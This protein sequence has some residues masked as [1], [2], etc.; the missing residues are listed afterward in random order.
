M[1]ICAKPKKHR[2]TRKEILSLIESQRF[3][4]A[5]SGIVLTPDVAELDHIIP[6]SKGGT[7]LIANLQVT[8]KKVN[9]MKG[10]MT[11]EEFIE[12]CRMISE[13]F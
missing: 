10:S 13:R 3:R 5:L 1:G 9:R 2:A 4:C 6:V 8:H 12:L 7:N 11:N